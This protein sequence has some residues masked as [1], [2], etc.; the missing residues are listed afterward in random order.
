MKEF[1][2]NTIRC[3]AK[4]DGHKECNYTF[5][6]V[7]YVYGEW[8]KD[9]LH[10]TKLRNRGLVKTAY[11]MNKSTSKMFINCEGGRI[12]LSEYHDKI[13][14]STWKRF[15]NQFVNGMFGGR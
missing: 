8:P 15:K 9:D 14:T 12:T 2:W 10:I 7:D 6:I 11:F 1:N 4:Y 3:R 13:Y 5:Y